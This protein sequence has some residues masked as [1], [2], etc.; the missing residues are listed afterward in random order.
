MAA[1]RRASGRARPRLARLRPRPLPQAGA[2]VAA[3]GEEE[4]GWEAVTSA[5][6]CSSASAPTATCRRRGRP[7]RSSAPS[8]RPT[9]P[10]SPPGDSL[11]SLVPA[12]LSP[13]ACTQPAGDGFVWV[14]RGRQGSGRFPERLGNPSSSGRES[15]NSRRFV[16][17]FRLAV[18]SFCGFVGAAMT[19]R[20][21]DPPYRAWLKFG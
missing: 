3:A 20:A 21:V 10:G 17:G 1:R 14:E 7:A 4:E 8:L 2:G 18:H 12:F 19:V 15:R 11:A 16:R 5:A 9:S 6:R 13:L